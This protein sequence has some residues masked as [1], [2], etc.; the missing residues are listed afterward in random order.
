M[1]L[2]SFT[3]RREESKDSSNL[4][5]EFYVEYYRVLD[6]ISGSR[7]EILI[8]PKSAPGISISSEAVRKPR[9]IKVKYH[10][11]K[12]SPKRVQVKT[13]KMDSRPI[14]LHIENQPFIRSEI[15]IDEQMPVPELEIEDLGTNEMKILNLS[16]VQN[17]FS[18]EKKNEEPEVLEEE[19]I[20]E[21]PVLSSQRI[22]H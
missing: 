19:S 11:K 21:I 20:G 14:D 4:S 7:K 9:R 22:E 13:L 18:D 2:K 3:H 10:K 1:N 6:S 5:T 16:S 15:V 12:P 8:R 17:E